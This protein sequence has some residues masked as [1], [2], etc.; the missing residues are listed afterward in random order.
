M[1]PQINFTIGKI[2]ICIDWNIWFGEIFHTNVTLDQQTTIVSQLFSIFIRISFLP[3]I[4][5]D[6]CISRILENALDYPWHLI[7]SYEL[8]ELFKWFKMNID[9]SIVLKNAQNTN[10]IDRAVLE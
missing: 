8:E 5:N 7:N 10:N 4:H 1:I 3:D 9:P 2:F 6:E